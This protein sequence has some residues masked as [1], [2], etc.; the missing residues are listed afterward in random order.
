MIGRRRNGPGSGAF[1]LIELLVV[2]A[3]I[4]ILAGLLLP[5]LAR[6]KAKAKDIQCTSN[7]K[8]MSLAYIMYV[9][10]FNKSLAYTGN[11]DLWM[12]T[13]IAY[14][15][16]VDTIRTCPVASA[17]STR[18]DISVQY[19]YGTGDQMWKWAPTVTNYQGSFAFNGWLYG[20]TYTVA[21]LLG[22][23]N[24][25]KYSGE[26]SVQRSSNTPLFGD[27]MWIDGW[28]R[29]AEGPAKDLYNGN[30]NADM[31]RFTIARH[32]GLGPRS[33]PR[34]LTSSVGLPGAINIAFVDGH[35]SLAK[36]ANLWRLDWHADW[37]PPAT[38]GNPK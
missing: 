19:T 34:A 24:S 27:A 22:T 2:I 3:I 20:G 30:G 23:P 28:P 38:I 26:S 17:A 13:L 32:G 29:E 35:A 31:G 1:T 8:Q 7:I 16:Q 5:A 15:S 36:L 6:A 9:S 14:H 11:Q 25:W 33:A 37:S 12:A 10:D 4:A 21:D 18:T